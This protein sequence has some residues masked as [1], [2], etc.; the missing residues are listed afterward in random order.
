MWQPPGL[1]EPR[2]AVIVS[3]P[4][5]ANR[6]DFVEV[7]ICS[8]QRAGRKAQ[9]HEVLLDEADGFDWPTF[10]KCD[11]IYAAPRTVLITQ[12]GNVTELRRGQ[13]VQTMI[14]AQGWAAV[15]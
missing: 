2:P 8:T 6:K 11:L 15:L 1:T 5:R 12:K 9:A 7:I 13:L 3:H 4:P 14:A 10:C